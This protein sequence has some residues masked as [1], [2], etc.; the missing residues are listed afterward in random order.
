[1]ESQGWADRSRLAWLNSTTFVAAGLG[2]LRKVDIN[3]P[4]LVVEIP[5][6]ELP[7]DEF[8]PNPALVMPVEA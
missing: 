6:A 5:L 1:M 7:H 4:N 3:N 2:A 8:G